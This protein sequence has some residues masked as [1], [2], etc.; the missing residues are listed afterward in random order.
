MATLLDERFDGGANGVDLSS[1]NTGFSSITTSG[2]TAKFTTASPL[3][4]SADAMLTTT[5]SANVV[6]TYQTAVLSVLYASITFS[7]STVTGDMVYVI[8]VLSG[9]STSR[10]AV[11]INTD[12]TI[13]IRNGVTAVATSATV[14]QA[15]TLYRFDSAFNLNTSTC[16]VRIYAGA[17]VYGTTPTEIISGT[18]NSG[19]IDRAIFG[20]TTATPNQSMRVVRSFVSDSAH[21]GPLAAGTNPPSVSLSASTAE[22]IAYSTVTLTATATDDGTITAYNFSQ[23]GGTTVTLSGSGATRI[24]I[25]PAVP[26]DTGA[27]TLTFSVTVIDNDSQTSAP[28]T[29]SVLVPVHPEWW[30]NGSNQ[31]RPRVHQDISAAPTIGMIGD[32]LTYQL[33]AGDGISAMQSRLIAAGYADARVDAK[34]GRFVWNTAEPNSTQ[35]AIANW[36]GVNFEPDELIIALG[37]NDAMSSNSV[38]WQAAVNNLLTAIQTSLPSVQKIFWVNIVADP[39]GPQGMNGIIGSKGNSVVD[40]NTMLTSELAGKGVTILNWFTNATQNVTLS[41]P[42]NSPAVWAN[43][44]Q[45]VHMVAL[46]YTMRND[47]ITAQVILP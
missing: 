31:L 15:N 39:T 18:Y 27:Q 44:A 14:I 12:G 1:S 25:T 37:T 38:Y 35:D 23:T 17:A 46:G 47:W 9:V 13:T 2:G 32:S 41:N 42:A 29:A 26:P 22:A 3:E 28:A 21:P 24:F 19:T 6:A 34:V 45:H 8:G 33:G 10:G 5:T 43:D 4:G 40:Y 11:R 36:N 7:L 16:E 30:I 20:I